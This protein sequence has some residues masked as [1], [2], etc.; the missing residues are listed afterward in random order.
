ME[1]YFYHCFFFRLRSWE[2]YYWIL[3]LRGT[4]TIESMNKKFGIRSYV[5]GRIF[6]FVLGIRSVA[7]KLSMQHTRPTAMDAGARPNESAVGFT[8]WSLLYRVDLSLWESREKS[9]A[10][11]CW[12]PTLLSLSK[13]SLINFVCIFQLINLPS[14]LYAFRNLRFR[15]KNLG[16]DDWIYV[17]IWYY[18]QMFYYWK[19]TVKILKY[20]S[21]LA[22]YYLNCPICVTFVIIFNYICNYIQI[23]NWNRFKYFKFFKTI[24]VS[25]NF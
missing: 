17:Y 23:T 3:Y 21:C 24:I 14:H 6:P 25:C 5:R 16:S 7:L 10:Q 22:L 4:I 8:R 19:S 12:L 2:I 1:I 13:S 11:F 15:E 9:W 18:I 20:I